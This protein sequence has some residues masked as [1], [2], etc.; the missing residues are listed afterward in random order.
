MKIAL[1]QPKNPDFVF[2][3]ALG[4]LYIASI[5][6]KGGH[7][8]KVF[9][10]NYD[11]DY[12]KRLIVFN[13]SVV[14]FTCTTPSIN[15]AVAA[16]ETIKKYSPKIKI[17]MGGPHITLMADE[18]MQN[19]HVD[20]C[21]IREGEYATRDLI[22]VIA[23]L[24]SDYS[25]IGNLVYRHDGA[26]VK[27]KAV[28][29]LTSEELERLP[30][31]A[32]HLLDIDKVFSSSLHGLFYKDTRVLPVMTSRGCPHLCTYCCR[33][34]GSKIRYR[35]SGSVIA[36]IKY[37]IDTFKIREIY[38]EDD[39]FT[40]DRARAIEIL[41]QIR[42]HFPGLYIKFSNGLRADNVDE[43]ILQKIK[44]AGGYW[45][46]FGIESGS[47]STLS[48]MRKN[49]DLETVKKNV[50]LA[51]K[52]GLKVSGNCIIGYPGEGEKEIRESIDFFKKLDLDSFAIVNL[53][54]FPGTEVYRICRQKG[55]L[56]KAAE[57]Y[58]NYSFKIFNANALIKTP[59]LSEEKLRAL[60]RG[61]YIKLY[62]LSPKRF[63][64][65]VKYFFR[66]RMPPIMKEVL[67]NR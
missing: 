62:L 38:F 14:G 56:T 31:P 46:G 15:R 22:D 51:K 32:F 57:Q 25:A 2:M 65:L 6:E 48:M 3:P 41:D 24:S 50:R 61:A 17:I 30:Y 47:K 7:D 4:L 33:T 34:M 67:D 12:L 9:D 29:F 20:F 59:M 13:P 58:D 26:I 8:V 44:D 1:V 66:K 49:L 40:D 23:A 39:N 37:L 28:P 54:P 42:I 53:V 27:N 19:P 55:Y 45:V 60:I 52:L 35:S 16:A 10:E 43:T 36:E 11:K 5:L 18:V 64:Y 21:I 63:F